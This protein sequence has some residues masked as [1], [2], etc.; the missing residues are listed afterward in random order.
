M[1]A[2]ARTQIIMAQA[3]K[4][5]VATRRS[6]GRRNARRRRNGGASPARVRERQNMGTMAYGGISAL[7]F[8]LL[9]RNVKL[10]GI[11]NVPNSLTYGLGGAVAGVVLKSD[12]LLKVATGPLFAG[13]HSIGLRGLSPKDSV[14]GEW[15]GDDTTAGE[16]D[17]TTA[18]TEQEEVT[19]GEFDDL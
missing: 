18:G 16:W 15:D 9:Q 5:R 17:D 10:P 19:A 7:L 12:K 8:G 1:A 4:S 6:G 2:A 3:P 13:L 14:A 11:E